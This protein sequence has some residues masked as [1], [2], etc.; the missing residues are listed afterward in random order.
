MWRTVRGCAPK[1]TFARLVCK[2]LR[3]V[4][5]IWRLREALLGL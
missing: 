1:V 3:P 4:R 2:E 5:D